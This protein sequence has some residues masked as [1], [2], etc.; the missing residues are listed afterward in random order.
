M[1]APVLQAVD[2]EVWQ[3]RREKEEV[4]DDVQQLNRLVS[5]TVTVFTRP[6]RQAIASAYH[7][8][9]Q[10]FQHTTAAAVFLAALH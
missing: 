7:G 1:C 8:T 6:L 2:D 3:L 4:E 10:V 9:P 5:D